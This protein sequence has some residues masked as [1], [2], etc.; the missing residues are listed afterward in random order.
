MRERFARSRR[1]R[2]LRSTCRFRRSPSATCNVE[3][4]IQA[5]ADRYASEIRAAGERYD[6]AMNH[7]L[8]G[9]QPTSGPRSD[10]GP[11][12]VEYSQSTKDRA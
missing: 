6:V 12:A 10:E 5:A 9:H 7:I 2:G 3:A 8:A 4:Q 1:Q 11:A